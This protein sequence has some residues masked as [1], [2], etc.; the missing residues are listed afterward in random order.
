MPNLTRSQ[1]TANDLI[2][3]W[4]QGSRTQFVRGG[5]GRN[6]NGAMADWKPAERALIVDGAVRFYV[7]AFGLAPNDYPDMNLDMLYYQA[8][9]EGAFVTYRIVAPILGPRPNGV[10]VFFDLTCMRAGVDT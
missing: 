6:V 10:P 5:I 9:N 7:A 4:G 3:R 1:R 8:P 2:R